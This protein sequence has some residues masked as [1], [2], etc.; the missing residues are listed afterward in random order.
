MLLPLHPRCIVSDHEPNSKKRWLK[1]LVEVFSK[2]IINDSSDRKGANKVKPATTTFVHELKSN[3][4]REHLDYWEYSPRLHRKQF[5]PSNI[6]RFVSFFYKD[7][8][9]ALHCRS[10]S[11]TQ[12]GPKYI[13]QFNQMD[14]EVQ[15]GCQPHVRNTIVSHG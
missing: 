13:F 7:Y 10:I 15:K 2:Q 4:A 14:P 3:R 12:W 6:M 1:R 5:L 8:K 9:L 11:H